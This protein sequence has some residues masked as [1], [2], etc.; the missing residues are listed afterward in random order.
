MSKKKTDPTTAVVNG[1]YP[2]AA[3]NGL[4]NGV[5]LKRLFYPCCV[6]C[7]D[8][9]YFSIHKSKLPVIFKSSLF[10]DNNFTFQVNPIYLFMVVCLRFLH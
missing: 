7:V 2:A 3:A 1:T 4:V 8:C 10:W 5:Y 9:I 6:R